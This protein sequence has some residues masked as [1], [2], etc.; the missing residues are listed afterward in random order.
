MADFQTIGKSHIRVDAL[1]KVTGKATYFQMISE[2][3]DIIGSV[4]VGGGHVMA[5]SGNLNVFDHFF[6]G[7]D[8]IRGFDTRGF[9]PRLQNPSG[10][11]ADSAGGTT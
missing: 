9:G 6:L 3:E 1:E 5:T 2:A 4:S 8:I 11:Y 10:T 7:Q